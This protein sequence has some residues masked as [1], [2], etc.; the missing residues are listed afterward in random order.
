MKK[1]FAAFF[2]LALAAC[3]SPEKRAA[4]AFIENVAGTRVDMKTKVLKVEKARP[5]LAADS[6]VLE[7]R[8]YKEGHGSRALALAYLNRAGDTLGQYYL[9]RYRINNPVLGGQRQEI[10]RYFVFRGGQVVAA[11]DTATYRELA[12]EVEKAL[13]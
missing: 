8:N 4:K 9:I 10:T 1:L 5:M 12:V 11:I 7:Y 13:E 2:V 3:S 6:A